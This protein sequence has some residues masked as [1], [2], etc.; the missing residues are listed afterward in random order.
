MEV[1]AAGVEG[2]DVEGELMDL[3]WSKDG[4][5]VS[6]AYSTKGDRPIVVL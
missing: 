4:F 2:M 1:I 6:I 3:D 5:W